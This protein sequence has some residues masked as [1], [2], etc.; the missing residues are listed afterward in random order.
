MSLYGREQY[1]DDLLAKLDAV[2]AER[3]RLAAVVEAK[4]HL[5]RCHDCGHEFYAAD[6]KVPYC[7]CEKCNSADTRPVKKASEAAK[8]EDQTDAD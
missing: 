6:R 2:K 7:L 8:A 4:L 1:V 5:R 3:D